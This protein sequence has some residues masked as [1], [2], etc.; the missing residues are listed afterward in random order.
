MTGDTDE[1]MVD[2]I[3]DTTVVIKKLVGV[4]VYV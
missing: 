2:G 3:D 4:A 1:Y